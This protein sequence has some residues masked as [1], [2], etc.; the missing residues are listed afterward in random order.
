M[1]SIYR[2]FIKEFWLHFL[3][4]N[5]KIRLMLYMYLKVNLSRFLGFSRYQYMPVC[6]IFLQAID[7]IA[8][9]KFLNVLQGIVY[10]EIFLYGSRGLCGV[11]GTLINL[12]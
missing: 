2:V 10:I 1:K 12:L 3:K 6:P 8:E 4:F 11:Q 7:I 9:I 5:H